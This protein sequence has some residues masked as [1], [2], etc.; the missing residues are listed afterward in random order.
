MIRTL[1]IASLLTGLSIGAVAQTGSSSTN[2]TS[3]A[4]RPNMADKDRGKSSSTTNMPKTGE[5]SDRTNPSVST[6]PGTA[7]SRA[8]PSS[9]E[10]ER[11]LRQPSPISPH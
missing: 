7:P 4:S 5:M 8:R 6:A 1:L 3:N 9:V 11:Q 2:D 10:L